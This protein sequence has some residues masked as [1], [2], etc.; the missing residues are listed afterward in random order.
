MKPART[1]IALVV[2]ALTAC[3]AAAPEAPAAPAA[4]PA[5]TAATTPAPTAAAPTAA[6]AAVQLP[7]EACVKSEDG[8]ASFFEQFVYEAPVRAAYSAPTVEVRDIKDPAKLLGSEQPGPFRIAIVDNQ[9]SYN[10]PGKDAGQF[11]RVKMDRT[12]NGDRMRVD[13]VK[14]EFSPDEE[15]TKTLGKPE[16]YVFE[17]KQGCWQL[18]QQLR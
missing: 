1:V 6:P 13:F 15:V 7:A 5:T 4:A 2:L 11:A 8:F 17:F 18:T 9:W 16:A 14:A 12:L 3:K 10:E